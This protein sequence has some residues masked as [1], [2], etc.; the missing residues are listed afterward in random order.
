MKNKYILIHTTNEY[1]V[2][3]YQFQSSREYAGWFSS[4]ND[5]MGDFGDLFYSLNL[6]YEDGESVEFFKLESEWIDVDD[7]SI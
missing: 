7:P 3:I 1:G 2:C 4:D 5:D 6:D